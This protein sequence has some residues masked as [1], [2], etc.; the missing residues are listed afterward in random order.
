MQSANF[1]R[2]LP[3][4][5]LEKHLEDTILNPKNLNHCTPPRILMLKGARK[6]KK[7]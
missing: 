6:T 2:D 3:S 5:C 1:S 7:E 4:N